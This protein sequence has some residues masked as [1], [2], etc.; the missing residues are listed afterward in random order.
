M[1][2]LE[3]IA[4]APDGGRRL[5]L[6]LAGQ[7]GAVSRNR[8]QKLIEEGFVYI[9][10]RL[11]TR[12]NQ[13][14]CPGDRVSFFLTERP[15]STIRPEPIELDMV[16]EDD[17]FMVIN[18][19]RGM[20]VYPG[21]GHSSGT[22]VNALLYR[23]HTLS[24]IGGEE[25]PGIV[26]RLD[27][28]TTGLILAAKNDYSHG[29][30]AAQIRSRRLRR[31][32]LALAH[33]RVFPPAGRIEA[34]IGRHPRNRM[35]MAVVQGGR[36]AATRYRVIAYPGSFSLLRV[37]LETGRTHQI[38]VHMSHIRYPLVGDPLYGPGAPTA[39]PPGLLGGQ[40]LHARR[41]SLLHPRSGKAL[42]FTAPLPPD[43]R[44]AL[45]L[46]RTSSLEKDDPGN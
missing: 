9:N 45:R 12:K 33:G 13:R 10:D 30:L 1:N 20:V 18:K 38:R 8:A 21:P 40:A 19:P 42:Q 34:P 23:C 46:L 24:T 2:K 22:L 43:F 37:R 5:D 27:K 32:Y 7:A 41:L 44:K 17:D 16:F 29:S 14:L 3:Y 31:E 35:K 25:R 39:F 4:A 28:D 36:D 6:F 11:C 26:H 15:R